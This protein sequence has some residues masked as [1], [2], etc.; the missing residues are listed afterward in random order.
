[1]RPKE[2]K[3]ALYSSQTDDWATPDDL[4]AELNDF[5]GPFELDPCASADNAKCDRYYTI[6]QN[7][8]D[9]SWDDYGRVWLNPPYGRDIGNW[10]DKANDCKQPLAALL[11]VRTCTQWFH[12]HCAYWPVFFFKGRIKFGG[13]KHPAPFPSM[14]VLMHYPDE[15]LCNFGH[16]IMGGDLGVLYRW[17]GV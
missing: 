15:E 12:E 16:T 2:H 10:L 14:L 8:L 7:G 3:T 9:Q 17:A 11:P 4:F 13:A 1:M 5:I 6:E